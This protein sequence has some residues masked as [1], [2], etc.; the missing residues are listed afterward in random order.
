M[1]TPV[2][3]AFA[4][5]CPRRVLAF[6]WGDALQLT[7]AMFTLGR[8]SWVILGAGVVVGYLLCKYRDA[9]REHAQSAAE[10]TDLLM[11]GLRTPGSAG[12][13]GDR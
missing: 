4:A 11:T 1:R 6:T 12:H 13:G 5:S 10:Q 8:R 7:L 9:L 3:S 2:V